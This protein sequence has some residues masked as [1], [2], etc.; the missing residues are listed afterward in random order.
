MRWYAQDW[1]TIDPKLRSS[2]IE[3]LSG[4]LS[5]FDLPDVAATLCPP[6]PAMERPP[7]RPLPPPTRRRWP[8]GSRRSTR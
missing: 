8:G 2:I 7:C 3:G 4:F 6:K 1:L 5:V